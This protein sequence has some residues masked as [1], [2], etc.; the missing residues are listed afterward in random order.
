MAD[1]RV[2]AVGSVCE[3]DRRSRN[4]YLGRLARDPFVEQ[5]PLCGRCPI[6]ATSA[7]PIYM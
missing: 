6:S 3:I 5:V 2:K 7:V 4:E 1:S